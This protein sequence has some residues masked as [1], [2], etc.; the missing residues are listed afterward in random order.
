MHSNEVFDVKQKMCTGQA[1]TFIFSEPACKAN[2]NLCS[3]N[4]TQTVNKYLDCLEKLPDC[5]PKEPK[6]FGE[7]VLVCASPMTSLTP[8]CF[9][10]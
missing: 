7:S 6:K 5:D 8:G 3:A 4:D 1:S 10:Q 2:S 9:T